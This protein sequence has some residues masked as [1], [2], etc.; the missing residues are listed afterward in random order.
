MARDKK[1]DLRFLLRGGGGGEVGVGRLD[2]PHPPQTH[3]VLLR[4]SMSPNKTEISRLSLISFVLQYFSGGFKETKI[5][6]SAERRAP[7]LA[8]VEIKNLCRVGTFFCLE[9]S[10]N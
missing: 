5:G 9:M 2:I 1:S 10:S 3:S 6:R 4:R 8:F 7:Y